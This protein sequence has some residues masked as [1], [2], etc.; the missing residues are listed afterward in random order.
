M[1]FTNVLFQI[2]Q[3]SVEAL[4]AAEYL[5]ADTKIEIEKRKQAI[6]DRHGLKKD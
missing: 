2:Y 4:S 5:K 3:Y 1:G 6:R